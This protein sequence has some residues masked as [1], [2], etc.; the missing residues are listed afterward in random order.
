MKTLIKILISA[1]TGTLSIG[2]MSAQYTSY[3]NHN[4]VIWGTGGQSA[5]SSGL[6]G[7]QSLWDTGYG[8]GAGYEFQYKKLSILTGVE[9]TQLKTSL[10]YD[11]FSID[12]DNLYDDEGDRFMGHY[13]FSDNLDTYSLGNI[14]IPLEFGI[15]SK[16]FYAL[17]GVKLG[18][19][20]LATSHTASSV[21]FSG[22]YENYLGT[23]ENMPNHSFGSFTATGDFIPVLAMNCSA[24]AEAGV[25]LGKKANYRLGAF[26]DYGFLNINGNA[27]Q[28][29]VLYGTG[30]M[31]YLNDF[32]MGTAMPTTLMYGGLKL[33]ILLKLNEKPDCN[34]DTYS[35]TKKKR[36]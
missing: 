16:K 8:I 6:T 28:S 29:P 11:K 5:L 25:N 9:Y 36:K 32:M 23:F 24:T 34:C 18:F 35:N 13:T 33:T 27:L 1:I 12:V 14:N 22:T 2:N 19:N 10:A 20:I 4:I 30:N 26:I 7:M 31:P 3:V 17:A 21:A 15:R